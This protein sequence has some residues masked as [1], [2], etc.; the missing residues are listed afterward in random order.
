[1]VYIYL[2]IYILNDIFPMLVA[3]TSWRNRFEW[4]ELLCFMIYLIQILNKKV[5][6][7]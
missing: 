2:Y 7:T 6:F 4:F 3:Q 1:M 5:N